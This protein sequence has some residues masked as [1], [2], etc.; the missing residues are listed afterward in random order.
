M[1]PEERDRL[2]GLIRQGIP[3]ALAMNIVHGNYSEGLV[4]EALVDHRE[5]DAWVSVPENIKATLVPK[6]NLTQE[7][8]YLSFDGENA[9]QFDHSEFT[10]IKV[11]VAKLI[12]ELSDDADLL[13]DPWSDRW[14][15]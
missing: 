13:E 8:F 11:Y 6:W 5:S 15:S 1:E 2:N 14:R 12:T 10:V 4:M 3:I 7:F 9:D